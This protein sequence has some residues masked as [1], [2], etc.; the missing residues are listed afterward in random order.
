MKKR[1]TQFVSWVDFSIHQRER[2]NR[3]TP[4]PGYH[5]H[6]CELKDFHKA[7]YLGDTQTV[8]ELLSRKKN[9]DSRDRKNR[10]ALHLACASGQSSVVALLVQWKCDLNAR[11]EESKTA[12]IKAVQCRK[13]M[14]VTILLKQGADPNLE[15][16]CQNTA[17]HYAVLA[18][19]TSIAAELL[20]CNANIEAINKV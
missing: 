3:E 19:E 1:L 8:Q 15:D 17:L 10:T 16:N 7:A 2:R 11:D 4:V 6:R 9:V 13:E 20:R 12:L 18:E 5:V 14:C